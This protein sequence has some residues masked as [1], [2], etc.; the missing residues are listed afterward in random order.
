[1]RITNPIR[2]KRQRQSA[3]TIAEAVVSA[4]LIGLCWISLGAAIG[5]SLSLARGNREDLRATQILVQKMEQFRLYNW[6][7]LQDAAYVPDTFQEY[8]DPN[9]KKGPVYSGTVTNYVPTSLPANY[10]NK[11]RSIVV[12]LSWTS[13]NGGKAIPHNRSM[14]TYV[15]QYGMNTFTAP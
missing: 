11:V 8:F 7:Q 6:A 5:M 9:L 15:A 3:F 10:Q 4:L 13:Y 12:S 1:M 14:Q 2:R